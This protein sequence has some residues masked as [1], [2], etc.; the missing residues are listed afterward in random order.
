[1]TAAGMVLSHPLTVTTA[2][3]RWPRAKSSI[4]SAMIS[5]EMSDAFI[6]SVPIEIAS[7][8]EIVV[9][10]IG[11]PPSSRTPSLMRSARRR[12]LKLQGCMSVYACVTSTRG[13]L[14]SS[15]PKPTARIIARAGAR[16]G[17]SSRVPLWARSPL[18]TPA[19]SH[20][21]GPLAERPRA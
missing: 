1:M 18:T 12:W 10:S 6:P 17:P 19:S 13:R 20:S 16:R 3:T 7:F 11:V 15:S 21:A 14:K 2:S 5:R 4:E 8:T 9:A